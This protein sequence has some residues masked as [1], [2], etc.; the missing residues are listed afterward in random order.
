MLA[1]PGPTN[2]PMT[3][4]AM[5]NSTWPRRAVTIPTTTKITAKIHNNVITAPP[6]VVTGYRA[7]CFD[8]ITP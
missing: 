6:Q 7:G 2:S 4:K 5:P 8:S 1:P 3:I